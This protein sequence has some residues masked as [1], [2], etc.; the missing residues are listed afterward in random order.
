MTTILPGLDGAI[1]A[2]DNAIVIAIVGLRL[3]VVTD[4]N[5]LSTKLIP[6]FSALAQSRFTGLLKQLAYVL[7][8]LLQYITYISIRLMKGSGIGS[9][10]RSAFNLIPQFVQQRILSIGHWLPNYADFS[11]RVGYLTFLVMFPSSPPGLA[12]A[13]HSLADH[14]SYAAEQSRRNAIL[15]DILDRYE[16]VHLSNKPCSTLGDI[17]DRYKNVLLS[18]KPCSTLRDIL[19][20][21]K[22]VHLSNKPCSTRFLGSD[23]KAEVQLVSTSVDFLHSLIAAIGEPNKNNVHLIEEK[24]MSIE[25]PAKSM[26]WLD[27][28]A[29]RHWM[30]DIP[31]RPMAWHLIRNPEGANITIEH[32]ESVQELTT[33]AMGVNL[34]NIQKRPLGSTYVSN[35]FLHQV[36]E[37]EGNLSLFQEKLRR[38]D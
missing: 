34:T 28:P 20:R 31:D 35:L 1:T 8:R 12:N 21:Y 11:Q 14:M 19:N 37:I 29:Y 22:D 26:F 13:L 25:Q 9:L 32:K 6:F 3:K 30:I 24:P 4:P 38:V 33:A 27:K 2:L 36:M 5:F 17:L 18:N 10:L 15:R 23:R 7:I 16:D